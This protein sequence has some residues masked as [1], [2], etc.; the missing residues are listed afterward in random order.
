MAHWLPGANRYRSF[1]DLMQA[2]YEVYREIFANRAWEL[3]PKDPPD[4]I[5]KKL[6]NLLAKFDKEIEQYTFALKFDSMHQGTITGLTF[7]RDQVAKVQARTQDPNKLRQGLLLL[8][9]ELEKRHQ[10]AT[11]SRMQNPL[12]QFTELLTQGLDRKLAFLHQ[13]QA[14]ESFQQAA[15]FIRQFLGSGEDLTDE[16]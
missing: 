3:S 5:V 7:A 4:A 14:L 1:W 12:A 10:A 15:Y 8:A 2:E 13:H 16:T 11:R 9:D 6:P